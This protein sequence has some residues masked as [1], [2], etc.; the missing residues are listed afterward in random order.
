MAKAC[1]RPTESMAGHASSTKLRPDGIAKM[2]LSSP[3]A[4]QTP[5][6]P[7][8]ELEQEGSAVLK[9]L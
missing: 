5:T 3:S 6:E 7:M 9:G 2:R 4:F 8:H 1:E